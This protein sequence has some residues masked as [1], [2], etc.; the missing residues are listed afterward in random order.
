MNYY[1]SWLFVP[2]TN[3]RFIENAKSLNADVIIF[4]LEDSVM[5]YNKHKARH[6]LSSIVKDDFFNK[7][8]AVRVNNISTIW[9]YDDLKEVSNFD[10][11]FVIYP[12]A[13]SGEEIL[14]VQKI[15]LGNK[16]HSTLIPIIES[17]KGYSDSSAI[18]S[19]ILG[20]FVMFGSEDFL[21]DWGIRSRGYTFNNE[22]LQH[23]LF[24]LSLKCSQGNKL[25]ID[26]ATP[27]FYSEDELQSLKNESE[28]ALRM[29]IIGKMAVHPNQLAPINETFAEYFYPFDEN[30]IKDIY[31][32][33]DLIEK[34]QQASIKFNNSLLGIPELRKIIKQ[35]D[36]YG[37]LIIRDNTLEE[38]KQNIIKIL[39]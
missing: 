10:F 23:V 4:D 7:R 9:G 27:R 1:K 30:F 34:K 29:G 35:I 33:I 18:I 32:A 17:I 24:D 25:L 2:I 22:V 28:Y 13:S 19:S 8:I 5:T 11:D 6:K 36:L 14:N 37:E 26:C 16:C 15:L 12:K 38:L 21:S 20:R 3:D 39:P 31:T